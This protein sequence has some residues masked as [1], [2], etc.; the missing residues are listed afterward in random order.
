MGS[1]FRAGTGMGGGETTFLLFPLRL[2]QLSL[3]SLP[4]LAHNTGTV[5]PVQGEEAENGQQLTRPGEEARGGHI[6]CRGVPRVNARNPGPEISPSPPPN[7]RAGKSGQTGREWEQQEEW[8]LHDSSGRRMNGR[9]AR[10]PLLG[11]PAPRDVG[12]LAS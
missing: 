11:H 6:T 4:P 1:I 3:P 7:Q 8:A 5:P 2:F 10:G 9:C 12:G